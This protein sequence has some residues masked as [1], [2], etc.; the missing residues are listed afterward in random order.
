E[1]TKA[2]EYILQAGGGAVDAAVAVQLVLGLVEPQSSGIGGG[3][4]ALYYEAAT[5]QV[6]SF[7]GRETAPKT[8]GRYLFSGD[9]GKPM[10][11]YE[12]AVGGRAVGVPGMM[13]LLE[14]MHK[15]F[16]RVQWKD[17]FNP[18]ITL[19]ENG[20]KVTP[21]LAAMVDFD[22]DRLSEASM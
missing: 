1:A 7:D 19:S 22:Y 13:R 21:R 18:A 16:G 6:Y 20:F 12:A 9:D 11:F 3:G 8:A 14:M 2:G 4:F 10:D 15:R 5:K 17:L